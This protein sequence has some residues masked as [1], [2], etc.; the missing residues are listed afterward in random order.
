[1][2]SRCRSWGWAPVRSLSVS[3]WCRT[4]QVRCGDRVVELMA[5]D[6]TVDLSA[7]ATGVL[8]RGDAR[9]EDEVAPRQVIGWIRAA[10][11]GGSVDGGE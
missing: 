11:T 2:P 3:G 8:I 6:A 5:G 4:A 1:M 10:G 7:P 9:E